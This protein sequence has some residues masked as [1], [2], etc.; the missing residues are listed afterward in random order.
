M[1]A[2]WPEEKP[3]SPVSISD[4]KWTRDF[5]G[6]VE[7]NFKITNNTQKI[8]KYITMEWNC[9]NEVGDLVYDDITG[10]SSHGVTYTGPLEPGKVTDDLRNTTLFYD[11]SYHS[12]KLTK[13]Q[14][15]Y[16]DGTII[17]IT[18]QGYTDIVVE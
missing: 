11:Y 3:K 4:W 7:W 8:I 2:E 18:D 17:R 14:V 12:S 9:Y 16:M 5:Y 1:S 10:E 15:E 6:G 13:L